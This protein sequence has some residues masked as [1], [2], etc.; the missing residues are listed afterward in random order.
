MTFQVMGRN[1][2][3]RASYRT[4]PERTVIISIADVDQEP[5]RFA[6]NPHIL[7]ICRVHF[8]DVDRGQPNCITREDAIQI[9]DFMRAHPKAEHVLVHCE[10]GVSRSAG[11][12]AA[13]MKYYTGCDAA[14]F[15]HPRFRPN[16]S[17]YRMVLNACFEEDF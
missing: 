4:L 8:D 17:V 10:A 1:E 16:M 7:A 9:R 13:L 12:A 11:A 3:P 5:V 2:A 6:K 14:I 15:D